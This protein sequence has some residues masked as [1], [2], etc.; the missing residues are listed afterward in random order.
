[1]EKTS[2]Q[3]LNKPKVRRIIIH[4]IKHACF[5]CKIADDINPEANL[6]L[7][8][9]SDKNGAASLG[10]AWFKGIIDL[11]HKDFPKFKIIGVLD[12]GDAPGHALAALRQGIS[13]IYTSTRPSVAMKIKMIAD[14]THAIVRTRRPPMLNLIEQRDPC[15]SLRIFLS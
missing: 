8:L 1:M 15:E 6:V 13:C 10:P 4:G 5:A 3:S 9:W 7:E 11:V 14:E 12:C 2:V